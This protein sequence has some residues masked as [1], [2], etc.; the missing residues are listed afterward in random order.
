MNIGPL[1]FTRNLGSGFRLWLNPVKRPVAFILLGMPFVLWDILM[2]LLDLAWCLVQV[3]Y[4]LIVGV[5]HLLRALFSK[6]Q[7]PTAN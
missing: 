5:I 7:S 3:A 1:I 2:L 6:G 4:H